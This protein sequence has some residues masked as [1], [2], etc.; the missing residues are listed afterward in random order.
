VPLPEVRGAIDRLKA[1]GTI[2]EVAAGPRRRA[3]MPGDVV[4]DLEDRVI[5]AL[6]RIHAASPRLSAIPRAR[7]ASAFGYLGDDALVA[8]L[9]ERLRGRGEVTGDERTVTLR[10]HEPKLS[11]G[12]R[13]LKAEIAEAYHAG[14]MTPPD[15]SEWSG[16]SGPR[17]AAVPELLVLL[18]EEERIVAIGPGLYLDFE[19]AVEIRRLVAERLADGSAMSMADLRDLLGT[20]RKYAVP[21]GEYLDRI[22]LTRREGDLRR[23][24]TTPE[25]AGTVSP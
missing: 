25:A 15:P 5:R 22:G 24:R 2:V 23:L 20:T 3:M 8:G 12:E 11:Q 9:I 13:K 1:S 17:A 21:I 16:L 10:G 7:V 6:A 14:G 4:A 19:V 18:C